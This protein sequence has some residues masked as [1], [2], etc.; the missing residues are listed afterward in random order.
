MAAQFFAYSGT[1]DLNP[2]KI[3]SAAPSGKV[4]PPPA[5]AIAAISG[6]ILLDIL[7][8]LIGESIPSKFIVVPP[9]LFFTSFNLF[10]I[11]YF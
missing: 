6:S 10:T 5:K 2:L 7:I 3:L 11:L 8:P 4:P 1:P 9:E